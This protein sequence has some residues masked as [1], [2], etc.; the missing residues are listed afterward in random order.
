MATGKEKLQSRAVPEEELMHAPAHDHNG[1]RASEP[2]SSIPPRQALCITE[3]AL[4]GGLRSWYPAR[5]RRRGREEKEARTGVC[6][7]SASAVVTCHAPTPR[8]QLPAAA[9]RSDE[10][11]LRRT[12]TM[13]SVCVCARVC[14]CVRRSGVCCAW[15]VCAHGVERIRVRAWSGRA[16]EPSVQHSTVRVAEHVPTL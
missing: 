2:S 1:R 12:P 9:M 5:P 13:H 16:R 7:A 4:I 10:H 14:V 8:T 3:K 6:V 11:T 15:C